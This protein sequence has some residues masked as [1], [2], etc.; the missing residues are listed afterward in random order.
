MLCTKSDQAYHS[1]T[2]GIITQRNEII[3]C[4][5]FRCWR[6]MMPRKKPAAARVLNFRIMYIYHKAETIKPDANMKHDPEKILLCPI[7][8]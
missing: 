3:I 4:A 5:H 2:L 7:L 1:V 6:P 8:W